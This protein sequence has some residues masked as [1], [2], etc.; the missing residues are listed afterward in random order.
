MELS[1]A[2]A[3]NSVIISDS[4]PA[5]KNGSWGAPAPKH[6]KL[7]SIE[8]LPVI[9]PDSSLTLLRDI[10]FLQES[11]LHNPLYGESFFPPVS[12]TY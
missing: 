4:A 3:E 1:G 11:F 6:W 2:G 10:Y 5:E 7:S 8:F 9:S 12:F